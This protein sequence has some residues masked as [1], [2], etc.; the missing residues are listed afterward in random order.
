MRKAIAWSFTFHQVP[1]MRATNAILTMRRYSVPTSSPSRHSLPTWLKWCPSE[2]SDPPSL[3][4]MSP[5][6]TFSSESIETI[7]LRSPKANSLPR[8]RDLT[9]RE[10]T[11]KTRYYGLVHFN[12]FLLFFVSTFRRIKLLVLLL[13]FVSRVFSDANSNTCTWR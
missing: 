8:Q 9:G 7:Y 12:I 3:P 5:K 4:S 11:V 13:L 10:W 6:L 1:T 2:S